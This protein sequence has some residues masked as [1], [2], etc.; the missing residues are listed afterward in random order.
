MAGDAREAALEALTACR[1]A[2]AWTDGA[3]RSAIRRGG[4]DARDSALAAR[5]TYGVVQNRALLDHYLAGFCR[6]RPDKLEPVI[7]DILHIAVY[8]LLFLD[9]IP[10]SAAVNRAVE[11]T[12]AHHRPGAAGMVNGVLRNLERNLAS[13]QPPEDLSVRYSHPRWLCD[14]Y[15]ALLGREEA[16]RLLSLQNT[17]EPMTVQLNPLRGD[18]GALERA[19]TEEGVAWSRHPWLPG[20][21]QIQGTGDLEALDAFRRGLFFVQDAAARLSVTAAE[22]RPG[23][24]V[25]DLCAAPGGKSFAAAMDMG[26][27][28]YILARDIH[29]NKLGLMDRGAERLGITCMTTAPGDARRCGEELGT[30][31]DLVI[32]DVPCSGLGVIRKKPDIRRKRP[33]ELA[34]LPGIQLDI[35][36]AAA[37]CVR[38]GGVLLY[39]TCTVLP[40]ENEGVTG[41]FLAERMDFRREGFTLPG[42]PDLG[43]EG[44]V[45][46]WP[47]RQGTDGFYFCKLRRQ[48]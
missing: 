18:A 30:D 47:Q 7:R 32:C 45:T 9:K 12:K 39:A 23:M 43:A 4:L 28:G 46:L 20:A 37:G 38:R 19:L 24:R 8:Q 48:P 11:M 15:V 34:A 10:H 29:P 17:P 1:K 13:L 2:E 41:A 22:P 16:E 5:L 21:Y 26:N 33:E 31:F 3:L 35:L 14:R 44:Q 27:E 36:R 40:E 6:Q 25:L 42:L